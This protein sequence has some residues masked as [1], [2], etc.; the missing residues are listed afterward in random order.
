MTAKKSLHL[1]LRLSKKPPQWLI[2]LPEGE[3]NIKELKDLTN[4]SCVNIRQRLDFLKIPKKY[5]AKN[6]RIIVIYIWPGIIN[7]EKQ[8]DKIDYVIIKSKKTRINTHEKQKNKS[9]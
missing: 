3:Y 6:C 5:I 9:G 8:N 4:R 1:Y 2:K 7:Y